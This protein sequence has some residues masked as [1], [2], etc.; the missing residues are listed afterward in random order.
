MRFS[1]KLGI[2]LCFPLSALVTGMVLEGCG[3]GMPERLTLFVSGDSRGYLEP[4]G[5][6]IDQAG[7]LPGRA[8]AIE[9][10]GVGEK[11][12]VDVGN[13]TSGSRSYELL[14]MRYLLEGMKAIGYDA[15]NLGKNEAQL[16][17]VTLSDM[18]SHS[19][20]PFLSAN[21]LDKKDKTPIADRYR[22]IRRGALRVGVTGVTECEARDAG[23]G[24]EVRPPIEALADVIPDLKGKCDFVVVLAFVDEE[25]IKQI[26]EKFHEVDCILGGDVPQSSGTAQTINR[27]IAFNV[28][29]RG[30]VLGQIDLVRKGAGYS[31]ASSKGIRIAAD[32]VKGPPAIADLLARYKNELRERRF[33]LASAEGMERI[34]GQETTSDEFVGAQACQSCHASSLHVLL[35]SAHS[36]AL[37]TLKEKKSEFDPE[38]LRCHTVG[39]GLSSGYI[40]E[41]TTPQLAG[42]QCEN[43]HGR[44]KEHIAKGVKT[45]LKPVTPATCV[46]CHD[47]ENSANFRFATFW[48]KI[49]H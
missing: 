25:T 18:M 38:C 26:A 17:R 29:D 23:P 30:K 48:P 12:V 16:D 36:H 27:A 20:L 22:I 44:A 21:V 28:V 45:T 6:R 24:I 41:K 5:C 43:C 9:K 33:E 1:T 14:K 39:Y 8:V 32:K 37:Q 11:L 2:A 46:N 40:D 4:C 47:E 34:A 49:A 19:G 35:A 13:L 42:V 31:V 15:V 10:A 3:S 7:G